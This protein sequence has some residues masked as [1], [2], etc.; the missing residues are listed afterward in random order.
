MLR[1]D[2]L[3]NVSETMKGSK[4]YFNPYYYP[5][6]TK[7]LR[8][9]PLIVDK[10]LLYVNKN[11]ISSDILNLAEL[12][13]NEGF[14]IPVLISEETL[15]DSLKTSSCIFR[16]K[17]FDEKLFDKEY[18]QA[19]EEDQNDVEFKSTISNI[20]NSD[21]EFNTLIDNISFPLNWDLIFMN[22]LNVPMYFPNNCKDVFLY[23]LEKLNSQIYFP[24]RVINHINVT[25]FLEQI[26]VIFPSD[27]TIDQIKKFRKQK[28]AINFRN[29][30]ERKLFNIEEKEDIL[31]VKYL[32]QEFNKLSKS[33]EEH[34]DFISASLGG[35][36]GALNEGLVGAT[37]GSVAGYGLSKILRSIWKIKGPNNWVFLLTDFENAGSV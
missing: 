9:C 26:N 19:I 7:L 3:V 6:K 35:I 30:L 11:N 5:D 24:K 8:L 18:K 27:L 37:I 1:N 36:I 32:V 31:R 2:V 25:N 29:W 12:F 23:K 20:Q 14:L 10:T 15:P 16:K 34:A 22:T 33:H 21:T 13:Q 17:L 28:A 4:I